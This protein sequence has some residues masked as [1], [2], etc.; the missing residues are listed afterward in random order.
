MYLRI[1][2]EEIF[3]FQFPDNSS[4]DFSYGA[5]HDRKFPL[6]L[7]LSEGTVRIFETLL[8]LK[9][10]SFSSQI[11]LDCRGESNG[12]RYLGQR[13]GILDVL[14]RHVH[15]SWQCL[16]ISIHSLREWRRSI[17][18]TLHHRPV[19]CW[20]TVL[21]PGDDHGAILQQILGENVVS[22]CAMLLF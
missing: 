21:L 20:Q 14:H 5:Q 15:R 12:E 4:F 2:K 3:W 19:S 9:K 16:A 10:N 1:S 18:N 11:F 7:S 13:F 22:R 8:S 6:S 17:S